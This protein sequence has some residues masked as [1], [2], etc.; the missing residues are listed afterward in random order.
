MKNKLLCFALL[1]PALLAGCGE[2]NNN[3][4]DNNT[5]NSNSP[6][7]I[8]REEFLNETK[9]FV[10][11]IAIYDS[12]AVSSN[13]TFATSYTLTKNTEKGIY[14]ANESDPYWY[15][16]M[17]YSLCT[18]RSQIADN[19]Q[20]AAITN[21]AEVV[22]TKQPFSVTQIETKG[23]NKRVKQVEIKF[24]ENGAPTSLFLGGT[25]FNYSYSGN[26]SFVSSSILQ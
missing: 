23:E 14:N 3:N 6:I 5:N 4:K 24:D 1:I 25:Q 9:G 19:D 17:W 7:V 26:V 16:P 15:Y 11:K 18:I 2:D 8:S 22:L 20:Y 13:L 12:C 10:D 21:D